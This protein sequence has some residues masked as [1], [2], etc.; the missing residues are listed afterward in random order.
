MVDVTIK[1]NDSQRY[2]WED[3]ARDKSK[4]DA[5]LATVESKEK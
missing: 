3:T 5:E 2:C 4:K 1:D